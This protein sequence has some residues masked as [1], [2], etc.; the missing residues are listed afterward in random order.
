ME[1]AQ[2]LNNSQFPPGFL[3]WWCSLSFLFNLL[4]P[5]SYEN[6]Q[7]SDCLKI[8]AKHQKCL[9]S[10]CMKS[11]SGLNC[12]CFYLGLKWHATSEYLTTEENF[13]LSGKILE[14]NQTQCWTTICSDLADR[15]D[16][17]SHP[18]WLVQ[19]EELADLPHTGLD[20]TSSA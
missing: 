9:M 4:Y 16:V 5:K 18:S 7:F 20:P 3:L 2:H 10:L 1:L 19:Q 8:S 14:Q 6:H 15:K 11:R 12:L 17:P 13:L